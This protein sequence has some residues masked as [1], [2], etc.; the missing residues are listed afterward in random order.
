MLSRAHALIHYFFKSENFA[1]ARQKNN[2]FF[3]WELQKLLILPSFFMPCNINFVFLSF[4]HSRVHIPSWN[5]ERHLSSQI[6]LNG[7]REW[8]GKGENFCLPFILV[9]IRTQTS[10]IHSIT[11]T[12]RNMYEKKGSDGNRTSRHWVSMLTAERIR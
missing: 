2:T 5:D 9:R 3:I 10:Y 12:L 6:T 4:T 1:W 7:I 8:S 11:R